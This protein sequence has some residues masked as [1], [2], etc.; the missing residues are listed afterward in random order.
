MPDEHEDYDCIWQEW[1][2]ACIGVHGGP[3]DDSEEWKGSC[4][5]SSYLAWQGKVLVF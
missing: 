4:S 3:S 5:H 1:T 2:N